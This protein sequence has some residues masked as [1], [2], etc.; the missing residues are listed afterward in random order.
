MGPRAL[1]YFYRRR[2]RVHALQELLAGLGIAIG[3]ALV[4][5]VLLAS[6]SIAGS[7]GE[8]VHALIGPATLQLRTRS[9]DGFSERTL[10]R[11]QRLPGVRQTAPLLE[12]PASVLG[13]GRRRVTVGIVGA[14]PSLALMDGLA[15]TIPLTTLA[16]GEIGL[17][18]ASAEAIGIADRHPGVSPRVAVDLRGRAVPLTVT[19]VLRPGDVGAAL[20]Q[21]KVAIMPLSSLQTLAGLPGRIT[22]VL[23]EAAPGREAA[24]REELD[25]VAAGHLDVAPA[26]QE[27]ALVDLAL[28]P[29]DQATDFFAVTAVLLGFLL[30]LNAM[31]LTTPER[32][33][34]IIDLR[35]LGADR[36]AVT[37]MVLFQALCLGLIAS[38]IGLAA[39]Y[40]L[41]LGALHLSTE[42]L[43][44]GFTLSAHTVLATGPVLLATICGVLATLLASAV[45]LLDVLM[46]SRALEPARQEH[47]PSLST[48][49]RGPS[50]RAS[51]APHLPG[52][53]AC[54]PS[55]GAADAP[56]PPG[57]PV[58]DPCSRG[59]GA[60][61]TGNALGRRVQLRLGI[62]TIVLLAI[63]AAAALLLPR[64][65]LI[66]S[67]G[68]SI[69][70]VLAVPVTFALL[71]RCAHALLDQF[72]RMGMLALA[73][74]SLRSVKLRSLA[75]AATGAVALFGGVALGGASN[76]VLHG[77]DGFVRDDVSGGAVWVDNFGDR[78]SVA[79]F[80]TGNDL[81][82]IAHIPGVS[83]VR[84][85]Q[86]GFLVTGKRRLWI[87][88]RP[89]GSSSAILDDEL[90]TGTPAL[91]ETRLRQGGWI[92]LSEQLASERHLTLGDALTLPTPTG[93]HAYRVAGLST[94]LGWSPG[95]VMM[96]PAD[97]DRAWQT[98]TPTTLA[99][100]LTPGAS[101][102]TARAAIARALGPA[103]GL[104]VQTAREREAE[105]DV[106]VS[107]ALSRLRYIST[108]LVVAAI[109]ALAA[110]LASSI[111]Q[112]RP[113]LA[114]LRLA[115]ATPGRLAR[116]LAIETALTL[117]AGCLAG[118]VVGVYGEVLIDHYLRV[119]S[120]LPVVSLTASARPLQLL[121]LVI[122]AV[123]AIVAIPGRRAARVP[124]TLALEGQ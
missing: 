54:S 26:D 123:L 57:P 121:A 86:G 12:V 95:I 44:P 81:A 31:L 13:P 105:S 55:P 109:L 9:I 60:A 36:A 100:T 89:L 88:V 16:P 14:R 11:V 50:P 53:P 62:A 113:Q 37:Q 61:I 107:E 40:V 103:S 74:S 65:T 96:S 42:Y 24:V 4:L 41:S 2:L 85:F 75:L 101:A 19:A 66:V 10:E 111:S 94:T 22:R 99:V 5:G 49:V 33:R 21:T 7:A 92:V 45:P 56:Y 51:G 29:S 90:V 116:M 106:A 25:R 76:D 6:S 98:T 27:I 52:A 1:I 93:P 35:L 39:G 97:Y 70:C 83:S 82:R 87:V 77:I 72:Q 73:L 47:D 15:R 30:A 69:T 68:L 28:G 18:Q 104:Q 102:A 78:Q 118:V 43:A 3:V 122:A 8:V 63:T 84:A 110:A 79:D 124:P 108:L 38:L 59:S 115:G 64:L 17:S 23:I 120:G 67:I 91:A 117:G 119:I 20:S 114:A 32:R 48:H 112:R 46:P 80:R 58:R 34:A 71:L